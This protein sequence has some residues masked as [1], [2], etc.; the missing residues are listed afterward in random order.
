[1]AAPAIYGLRK[2][3]HEYLFN[4]HRFGDGTLMAVGEHGMVWQESGGEWRELAPPTFLTL[5]GLWGLSFDDFWVA[6][7]A[8]FLAHWD[9]RSWQRL[10]SG[11]STT[12][13]GIWGT[14]PDDL[15]AFGENVLL[16][17]NGVW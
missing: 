4:V 1:M 12:L 9:G 14:G 17:W 10:E 16:H 2:P 13:S 11:I 6:G 15:Y 7:N 5:Y 8:G 3:T